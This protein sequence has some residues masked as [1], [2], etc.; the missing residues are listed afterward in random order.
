MI[1]SADAGTCA[2]RSP[3]PRSC[4]SRASSTRKSGLPPVRSRSRSASPSPT[5]SPAVRSR[6]LVTALVSSPASAIRSERATSDDATTATE[7]ETWSSSRQVAITTIGGAPAPL[8]RKRSRRRDPA[9]VQCRSSRAMTKGCSALT[10]PSTPSTESK[11]ADA[12]DRPTHRQPVSRA[13]APAATT[14]LLPTA[15]PTA[16]GAHR[17]PL[18]RPPHAAPGPTARAVACQGRPTPYRGEREG[19]LRRPSPLPPRAGS[20]SRSRPRR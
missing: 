6:S 7:S 17:G 1:A 11:R 2:A 12:R 9:S 20:S 19:R 8:V 5:R 18:V 15:G 10:E 14:R 13:Q 3:I 16:R 4:A